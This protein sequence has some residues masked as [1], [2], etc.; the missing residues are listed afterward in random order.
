MEQRINRLNLLE[1]NLTNTERLHAVLMKDGQLGVRCFCT[2]LGGRDGGG[3][4]RLEHVGCRGR[5][6]AHG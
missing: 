6:R 4:L 1:V 2:R 3:A 5:V